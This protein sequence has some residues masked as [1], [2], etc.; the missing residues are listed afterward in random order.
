MNTQ[1]FLLAGSLLHI[2]PRSLI[3]DLKAFY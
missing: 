1:E 2:A 3:K